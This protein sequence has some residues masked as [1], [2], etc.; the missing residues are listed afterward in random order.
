[1]ALK[2]TP[3][4]ERAAELVAT[5]PLPFTQVAKESRMPFSRLTRLRQDPEF[6]ARVAEL[7]VDP[8]VDVLEVVAD[9]TRLPYASKEE[10]VQV[11]VDTVEDLRS[12]FKARSKLVYPVDADQAEYIAQGGRSGLLV[13]KDRAMGGGPY[14]V[15]VI[16]WSVDTAS[17]K[18]LRALLAQIAA[19]LGQSGT[20]EVSPTEGSI[21][22]VFTERPDGP[23]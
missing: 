11:L 16:D 21:R 17:L 13:R 4:I 20:L 6:Q 18:E 8:D 5:T 12:V 22:V 7:R 1:M 9:V 23:Q 15:Q 10:R 3:S 2:W 14:M 19:E